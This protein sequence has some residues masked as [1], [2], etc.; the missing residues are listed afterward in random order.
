MRTITLTH[1]RNLMI[2]GLFTTV[3]FTSCKKTDVTPLPVIDIHEIGNDDKE[4]Y[5]G[6]DLHL[7]AEVVAAGVIDN[8]KVQIMPEVN[9]AGWAYTKTYTEGFSGQKN[10]DFHVH[11]DI[12]A[13]TKP[14]NYKLILIVTDKAGRLATKTETFKIEAA[15]PTLP[16]FTNVAIGLS[17]NKNEVTVAALI[18]APNKI[19][20]IEVEIKSSAWSKTYTLDDAAMVGQTTYALNK[21]LDISAAPA[22]HYHIYIKIIDQ[23]TKSKTFEAHFDK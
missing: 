7:D 21:P 8:I 16:S 22:G 3:M 13:N 15:D 20:K 6:Q 5:A 17:T 18:D 9:G 11:I 14:G 2:L 19:A 12:P 10:A 1:L 4:A 23:A